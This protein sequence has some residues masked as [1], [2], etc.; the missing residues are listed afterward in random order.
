MS[1]IE[2]GDFDKVD[3]R[4]GRILSAEPLQGARKPAY[5]LSIDF[6][7]LG[8]RQSSAQ[9]TT[10]YRPEELV[11]RHVVAVTNFA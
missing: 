10:L 5:K 8:T 1:Q 9:V 2:Y 7:E 6:G 4:V 11:G 3:I